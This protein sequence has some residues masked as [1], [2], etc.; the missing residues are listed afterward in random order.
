MA[1]I[2]NN[3]KI[4]GGGNVGAINVIRVR[5]PDAQLAGQ[6]ILEAYTAEGNPPTVTEGGNVDATFSA[7]DSCVYAI[8]TFYGPLGSETQI[9]ANAAAL[10]DWCTAKVDANGDNLS[11]IHI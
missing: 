6:P 11:L 4:V 2:E 10:N 1:A 3:T 5:F 9:H 8:P 7:G